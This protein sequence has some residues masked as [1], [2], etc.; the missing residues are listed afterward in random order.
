MDQ[1]QYTS[2][3]AALKVL[4]DY[5]QARGKR[6]PWI[7]LWSALCGALLSGQRSGSAISDWV[8][9]HTPEVAAWLGL[10]LRHAPSAST[11]RRALRHVDVEALER[12][13]AA[14]VQTLDAQEGRAGV[15]MGRDGAPLRGQAVDGKAVRGAGA[16]GVKVHLL[17]AVRHGSGDTLAQQEVGEKTNEIPALAAFLAAY[18]VRDT[19]VTVDALHT[20]R[21]TAQRILDQGG[22]Y[23]MVVKGNQPQLYADLETYF[24]ELPPEAV[25][26][27]HRTVGKAHGRR[28]R[29][30]LT[31]TPG[32][33]AYLDWPGVRQVAQRHC[34]RTIV[35]TGQSHAE[36]SY[37]V[38]SL[39]EARAGA[40]QLEALWRGHWTI[41][42]RSHYVRDETLGEDHCQI[43][44]G[45]A[46]RALAA[47]RNGLL[48]AVRHAGWGNIAQALRYY[49]VTASRA[50]ALIGGQ[51]G[52]SVVGLGTAD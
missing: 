34:Q 48:A 8:V 42:N 23:L 41:E 16:H 36:V 47:L 32:L 19:V 20:Q 39:D 2:V 50:L 17:S 6:Y 1:P 44:E 7:F 29:R 10:R 35:R 14:F 25:R 37:A 46:P 12:V 21:A 11:V 45:S 4:P 18:P 40:R 15:V 26:D 31:C 27:T 3:L 49:G 51:T 22:D 30:T 13:L 28:E 24:R 52:G 5:R 33:S 9:A 43:H 38:T